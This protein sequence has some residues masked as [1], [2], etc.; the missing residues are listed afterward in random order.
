MRIK[1]ILDPF[2]GRGKGERFLPR[3]AK[4]LGKGNLLDISLTK[5]PGGALFFGREA[6]QKDYDIVVVGGGDGMLNEVMNGILRVRNDLPLGI[7]PLGMSNTGAWGLGLP[8]DPIESCKIIL[9]KKVKRIDLGKV[10]KPVMRYFLSMVDYGFMAEMINRAESNLKLK[11]AFGT[12][13]YWISSYRALFKYKYPLLKVKADGYSIEGYAAIVSNTGFYWGGRRI[14]LQAEI[15][16]GY[17]DLCV[18][19]GKTKLDMHR[20]AFLGFL[21]NRICT[22]HDVEHFRT[23]KVSIISSEEAPGQID[24]DPFMGTPAEVEIAPQILPVIV[25]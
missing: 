25:P 14:A 3:I 6:A 10:A 20:Y 23:K 17:L 11:L 9:Q 15:D 24:G 12:L 22:L 13:L 7:I 2:A 19:K 8:Q 1:L 5:G 4:I 18:L 16:D 21:P